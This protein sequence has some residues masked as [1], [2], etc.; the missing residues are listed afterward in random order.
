MV[1][2]MGLG[3]NLAEDAVY[4][5]TESDAVTTVPPRTTRSKLTASLLVV[6][7]LDK[8]SSPGVVIGHPTTLE[9][10]LPRTPSH[11]CLTRIPR[12]AAVQK[13]F[14]GPRPYTIAQEE[15]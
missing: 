8:A 13:R 12:S 7:P 3:A 2:M 5:A 6:W 15:T 11:G 10:L 14:S 4:P 9:G 1:A